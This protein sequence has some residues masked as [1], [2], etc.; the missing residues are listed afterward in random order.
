[1]LS[2]SKDQAIEQLKKVIQKNHNPEKLKAV[3]AFFGITETDIT[4]KEVSDNAG[5]INHR[6]RDHESLRSHTRTTGRLET[7]RPQ[8]YACRQR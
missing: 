8:R 7:K 2:I 4:G 5:R 6:G 3:M 1:M